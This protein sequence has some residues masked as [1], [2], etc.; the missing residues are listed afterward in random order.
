MLCIIA[1]RLQEHTARADGRSQDIFM[2][3]FVTSKSWGIR[4]IFLQLVWLPSAIVA[5]LRR[6]RSPERATR[7]RPRA[8]EKKSNSKMRNATEALQLELVNSSFSS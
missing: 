1:V 2:N 8:F 5:W 4:Q 7:H 3:H 6:Q